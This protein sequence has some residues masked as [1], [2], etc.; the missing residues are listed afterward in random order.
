[1]YDMKNHMEILKEVRIFDKTGKLIKTVI[2][3]RLKEEN[4]AAKQYAKNKERKKRMK[5]AALIGRK[6]R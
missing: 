3:E 4:P 6:N 2:A 5:K 1:M